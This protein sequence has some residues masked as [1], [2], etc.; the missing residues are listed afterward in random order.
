MRTSHSAL[1]RTQAPDI[2]FPSPLPL[3][4]PLED[5]MVD[6]GIVRNLV[7]A[8]KVSPVVLR[9][10]VKESTDSPEEI[11]SEWIPDGPS[12]GSC[13]MGVR[14]RYRNSQFA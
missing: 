14:A 11:N 10:V 9:L 3:S 8:E 5:L 4:L 2:A 13:S 7:T 12:R 6:E 1:V